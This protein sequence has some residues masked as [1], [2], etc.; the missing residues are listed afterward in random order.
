MKIKSIITLFSVVAMLALTLDC[1]AQTPKTKKDKKPKTEKVEKNTKTEKPVKAKPAKPAKAEKPVKPKTAKTEKSAKAE[2]P[3]KPKTTKAEKPVKAAKLTKAKP[4]PVAKTVEAE[5][6]V[7]PTP[8]QAAVVDEPKAKTLSENQITELNAAMKTIQNILAEHDD[9]TKE[10]A[11]DTKAVNAKAARATIDRGI[12]HK[13]FVPKGQLI[14]GGTIGYNQF[15]AN[16]YEFLMVKDIGANIYTTGAKISAAWAFTNDV[17]AGVEL[18]YSRMQINFDNIDINLSE[19]M[20][21]SIKDYKTIRHVFT[22]SAFLRTYINIGNSGRFGMYNDVRVS[23]GG[24]QGKILN[25]EGKELVGTYEKIQNIGLT[26]APGIA[27]F[28]TDFLAIGASVGILGFN[29]SKTEQITNQVYQGSFE[30]FSANFKINLLSVN[31]GLQ[32][33]F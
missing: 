14:I 27:V 13:T 12:T 19:D 11:K 31:L 9:A 4:A 1:D 29:Y 6:P 17:A 22:A 32:F 16:D 30:S 15:K 21:F 20:V 2:K 8:V 24:G 5:T 23:F 10:H 33:Y 7:T 18:D 28:A 25:G 3:V 26:L